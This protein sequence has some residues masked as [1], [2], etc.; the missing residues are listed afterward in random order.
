MSDNFEAASVHQCGMIL[1]TET[2]RITQRCAICGTLLVDLQA[3]ITVQN[4]FNVFLV[5][6]Y[7]VTDST[8]GSCKALEKP[9]KTYPDNFCLNLVE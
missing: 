6:Q 2:G 1:V 4:G 9:F 3:P 5:G 8:D 7:V